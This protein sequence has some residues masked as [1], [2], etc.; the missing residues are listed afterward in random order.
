MIFVDGFIFT[1]RNILK[2]SSKHLC[3][4]LLNILI[5]SLASIVNELKKQFQAFYA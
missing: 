4:C 3:C 2:K 1:V 5:S